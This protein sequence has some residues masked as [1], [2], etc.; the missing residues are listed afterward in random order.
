MDHH[1]RVRSR[2]TRLATLVSDLEE[3]ISKMEAVDGVVEVDGQGM[4]EKEKEALS[5]GCD[6]YGV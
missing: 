3:T 6:E 5:D 4:K 2:L 1:A